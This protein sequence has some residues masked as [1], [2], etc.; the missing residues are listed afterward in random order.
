MAKH[1][2]GKKSRSGQLTAVKA[3]WCLAEL[4][5]G[6]Q[7]CCCVGIAYQCMSGAK[8]KKKNQQNFI[9]ELPPEKKFASFPLG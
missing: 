5:L 9:P 4:L 2:S 6:M 8:E 7:E 3:V 1:K